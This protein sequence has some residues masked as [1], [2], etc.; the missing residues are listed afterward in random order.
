ELL[1]SRSQRL[2][3]EFLSFSSS[4]RSAASLPKRNSHQVLPCLQILESFVNLLERVSL[5]DESRHLDPLVANHGDHFDHVLGSAAC[6]ASDL[7]FVHGKTTVADRK[8][9]FSETTDDDRR[10]AGACR[11]DDLIRGFRISQPFKSLADAAF[12]HFP[13]RLHGIFSA[14]IDRMGCPEFLRGFE[15]GIEYIYGNNRISSEAT[16]KLNGIQPDATAPDHQRMIPCLQIA[17]MFTRIS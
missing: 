3:G 12:G 5:G 16:Q 1:H 6:D 9:N 8:R 7:D 10:T 13:R 11:S 4:Q 14:G 17:S 15:L 2:R